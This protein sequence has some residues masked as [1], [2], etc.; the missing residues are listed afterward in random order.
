MELNK[1]YKDQMSP[2][3]LA[4]SRHNLAK[5]TARLVA[6]TTKM[7][8]PPCTLPKLPCSIRPKAVK[9]GGV[10]GSRA[11]LPGWS[12]LGLGLGGGQSLNALWDTFP[13]HHGT[14]APPP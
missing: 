13:V 6:N 10:Q 4:E 12:F 1:K 2:Q 5:V 7:T 8:A 11:D 14:R 9:G 3:S